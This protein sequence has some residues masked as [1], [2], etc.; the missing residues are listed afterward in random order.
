VAAQPDQGMAKGG[1]QATPNGWRLSFFL[2]WK[3]LIFFSFFGIINV[4]FFIYLYI[5]FSKSDTYYHFNG[6]GVT[7]NRIHQMF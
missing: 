2:F 6:A 5:F 4:L 3:K 1:S 7:L